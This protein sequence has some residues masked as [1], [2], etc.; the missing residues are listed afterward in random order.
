MIKMQILP[1]NKLI[2]TKFRLSVQKHF[3]T[4]G[5]LEKYQFLTTCTNSRVLL[6]VSNFL[7]IE[8]EWTCS[9]TRHSWR[10][11]RCGT[12]RVGFVVLT[13]SCL[14]WIT[15]K[16]PIYFSN[17]NF[18]SRNKRYFPQQSAW[19]KRS[20]FSCWTKKTVKDKKTNTIKLPV[21]QT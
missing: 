7:F 9:V 10:K 2:F 17:W 5:S 20:W 4:K 21:C 16:L 6:R 15:F 8:C 19:L 13:M 12:E 1:R 14:L 3:V 11:L 18:N